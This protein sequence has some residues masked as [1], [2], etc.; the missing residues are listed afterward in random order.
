MAVH[1]LLSVPFLYQ[2]DFCSLACYYILPLLC[3]AENR[4]SCVVVLQKMLTPVHF[5]P[6]HLTPSCEHA[7]IHTIFWDDQLV[8]DFIKFALTAN[9]PYFLSRDGE[10]APFLLV[11]NIRMLRFEST[12]IMCPAEK[13]LVIYISGCNCNCSKAVEMYTFG[14]QRNVGQLYKKTQTKRERTL[15]RQVFFNMHT[16]S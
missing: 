7:V 3:H 13:V 9:L 4:M 14:K 8:A 1:H 5:S 11:H 10:W 12:H 6:T 2:N 15:K 16:K